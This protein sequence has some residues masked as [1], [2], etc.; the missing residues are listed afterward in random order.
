MSSVSVQFQRLRNVRI[1]FG[2]LY[3]SFKRKI[4]VLIALGF[5]NGILGALGIGALVPLFSFIAGKGLAGAGDDLITETLTRF[6]GVIA[7]SMSV[8]AILIFTVILFVLQA[9][10]FFFF[11]YI[12]VRIVTDYEVTLRKKLYGEAL[13]TSWSYL[14]RQ[15]VGYF[16]NVLMVDVSSA[17]KV[18][19][20]LIAFMH[21][22]TRLVIYLFFAV[23]IS[24]LVTG[25]TLGSG[26][27]ILAVFS[28]ILS[29]IKRYGKE[30]TRL[31]KEIAHEM[32]ENVSGFKVI[33]AMRLE[34]IV[35]GTAAKLFEKLR[36]LK[37][38]TGTLR[39]FTTVSIQPV[40]VIFIAA[41]FLFL[42]KDPAFSIASFAVI[43]YLVHQIFLFVDKVQ[44][45]L[46]DMNHNIPF[47]RQVI[48][49]QREIEKYKEKDRGQRGF[50]FKN[51]LEFSGAT[52]AYNNTPVLDTVDFS[53]ARG[54]MVG[55]IGPSGAGKTT[56]VDLMLRL[57]EPQKGA[58][59]LDGVD[60]RD[61]RLSE[62]RANIG[63][64]S[65]DMFLKNDTVAANIRF[66][67]GGLD[68]KRIL[69]AAKMAYAYDFIQ[70]LP[71]G[72]DTV[73]GERGVMLSAGQRQRIVLARILARKPKILILDEATSALDNESED[74]IQKA[75]EK[76]RGEM[77]IIVI[78]HRLS[79]ITNCDRILVLEDGRIKEQGKPR[80]LLQDR[81]TY[82]HKVY[83]IR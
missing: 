13:A 71:K 63:Y 55:I 23:A 47:A 10:A 54:K 57:F 69:E 19:M 82:F 60:I 58:I 25:L 29:R 26:A 36:N 79:T 16:E 56:I 72:F 1:A 48:S 61:I 52:F 46:H 14:L 2:W 53:V 7:V 41:V 51:K 34:E 15:K 77:T 17:V 9:I 76:L 81:E 38:K 73:V 70:K 67:D 66:Y 12:G 22:A 44:S 3:G 32:N 4:A 6:F 11:K 78:A 50:S 31:N 30:N 59:L 5:L 40:S 8:Q 39:S 43:V 49:F 68:D 65:Q 24:P 83:H 35:T 27:V 20:M 18:L 45:A 33:K 37:I 42:Y 74:M 75:I 64:V 28:P 80:E 62:W 21:D